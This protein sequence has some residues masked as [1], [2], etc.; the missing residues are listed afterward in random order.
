MPV[1]CNRYDPRPGDLVELDSLDPRHGWRDQMER[2]MGGI[3]ALVLMVSEDRSCM[4]VLVNHGPYAGSI[5]RWPTID[6]RVISR[7][8]V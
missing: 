4:N 8:D 6:S 1:T 5:I 3:K 7:A 2:A